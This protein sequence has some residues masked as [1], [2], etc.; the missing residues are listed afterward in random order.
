MLGSGT[1]LFVLD[2]VK[3]CLGLKSCL[4]VRDR[5]NG[6]K[7]GQGRFRLDTRIFFC[8]ENCSKTLEWAALGSGGVTNPGSGTWGC[9]LMVTMV[10]LG[11]QLVLMT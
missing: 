6:L 7:L 1:D 4:C 5:G 11:S 3:Q 8:H 9:V 10:L 2:I